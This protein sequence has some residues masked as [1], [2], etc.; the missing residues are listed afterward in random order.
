MS[1]MDDVTTLLQTLACTARLLKRFEELLTWARMRIKPVKSRSLSIRKGVR[2]DSICFTVDNEKIPLLVDQPV[3]S[4]GRLYTANL[5]DKHMA[6]LIGSQLLDGLSKIDRSPLAGKFKVWCYQFTLYQRLMWPLK[7]CAIWE[8]HTEAP[9]EVHQF[10]LQTGKAVQNAKAH[11][12]TGRN[13]DAAKA[14]NQAITHLKHLEVVGF[15]QQG[16]AGF[17]WGPTPKMWSKAS[18][19]ERKDLVISEVVKIEEESYKIKAVSQQ[20]QGR[21]TTWEGVVNRTISWADMWRM[22]QA[23]LSFMIRATYDTLPRP[24]NLLLWYGTEETCHLCSSSNPSLQ[25]ILSGC[26]A[27]LTQG[28][29]RWRHDRVLRKLA[30][31]LEARRLKA[32]NASLL[33]SRQRIQFVQEGV[34][35]HSS[36][37]KQRSL[38]SPGGK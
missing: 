17:S 16:R 24:Q 12:R 35:S 36:S 10:G 33:T 21:W 27:A 19:K 23:R 34:K 4:L 8:H 9:L 18:R 7:L 38:L 20:Q 3:Q 13:W 2:T 1:Y 22:P 29:F 32:N 14:V 30:E 25:H 11:V 6:A 5:S 28:R 15:Q 31:I 26:K 37:T